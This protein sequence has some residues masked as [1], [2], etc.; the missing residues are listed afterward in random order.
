MRLTGGEPFLRKDYVEIVKLFNKNLPNLYILT[1]PTNGLL[2]NL[3]FRKVREILNFFPKRYVITVSL[4]GP[5]K[6]HDKIR[7]IKCSWKL[8]TS[9]FQKLKQL[10]R[11]HKISRS[12]LVI[13][14]LHITSVF[15]GKH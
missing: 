11:N 5:E 14:Y 4:D 10:E 9:T 7:G 8:A 13:L 1:T 3:I 6:I 2:S 15:L 12:F